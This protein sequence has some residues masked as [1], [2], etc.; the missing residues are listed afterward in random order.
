MGVTFSPEGERECGAWVRDQNLKEKE[1][2]R[3]IEKGKAERGER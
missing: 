1:R 2:E 3:R